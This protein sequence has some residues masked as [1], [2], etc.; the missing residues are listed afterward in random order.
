[1]AV[2]ETPAR[3]KGFT[4]GSVDSKDY[5]VYIQDGGMFDAPQR[6]VEMIE[7]PGRNGAYAFDHGRFNNINLT[8]QCFI[9]QDSE[10]DFATAIQGFRNALASQMGYQRLEDDFN[11]DEYRQAVFKDGVSIDNVSP[12]VGTFDITFDCKPQ[13]YLTSGETAISVVSGGTITNPTLFDANP[14]L[15]MDGYGDISVNGA[16]I[17]VNNEPL[18]DIV[19]SPQQNY[20]GLGNREIVPDLDNLN[21]GD[22]FEF[23]DGSQ[24]EFKLTPDDSTIVLTGIDVSSWSEFVNTTA[25]Y[26][27]ASGSMKIVLTLNKI[28]FTKDDFEEESVTQRVASISGTISYTQNGTAKTSSYTLSYVFEY[29]NS[30]AVYV[31]ATMTQ[32]PRCVKMTTPTI[33]ITEA[34]GHSTKAPI[35]TGIKIDFETGEAYTMINGKAVSAN[36]SVEM[37]AKLPVLSPGANVITY[38]NTFTT[39]EVTPR[40]WRV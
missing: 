28:P 14:L 38:D 19:I 11:I 12:K 9:P 40:F 1:M 22:A 13:R 5:G 30:G 32:S 17:T 35:E 18:G 29:E 2:K 34:W 21:S 8:Y 20:T 3:Y 23:L 25:T 26:P 37:P 39:M 7:I 15:S 16:G 33:T 6:D 4:F 36:S 31:L 27:P 24:I 10:T